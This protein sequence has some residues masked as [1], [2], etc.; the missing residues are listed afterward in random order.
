MSAAVPAQPINLINDTT[1]IAER[2]KE[3]TRDLRFQ[4]IIESQLGKNGFTLLSIQSVLFV[5]AL[6]I[7]VAVVIGS[8]FSNW[9]QPTPLPQSNVSLI[10]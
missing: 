4:H 10:L 3:I 2:P 8:L 6:I 9:H 5:L 7:I 1:D